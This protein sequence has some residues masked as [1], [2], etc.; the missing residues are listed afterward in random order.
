MTAECPIFEKILLLQEDVS[1]TCPIFNRILL[2]QEVGPPIY[3]I[4]NKMFLLQ[5][6]GSSTSRN[7]PSGLPYLQE[8]SFTS[9]SGPSDLS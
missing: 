3:P 9:M 1:P 8:Y 6:D 7:E 4:F 5:G 2:L